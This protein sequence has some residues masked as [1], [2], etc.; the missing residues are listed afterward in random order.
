MKEGYEFT[1]NWGYKAGIRPAKEAV[2][3]IYEGK[4]DAEI[5]LRYTDYYKT[6]PEIAQLALSVAKTE[7]NII[8]RALPNGVS[9]YINIPFCPTRCL[10]C[11]FSSPQSILALH[12][13]PEYLQALYKEITASL[14]I[15][16]ANQ[17]II[18]TI[19]IGGGTPTML[20]TKQLNELLSKVSHL[21]QLKELTVEAGRPDTITREKLEILNRHNVT[22]ISINPQTMND[23]TLMTIGRPHTSEQT[24]AAV[25]LAREYGFNNINM[26]IIAG[27]PNE[28]FEMFAHTVKQV[29]ALNP[30]NITVHAMCIKRTSN[31]KSNAESYAFTDDETV[32]NM[33]KFARETLIERGY[34]PYY[35][36]R[37]KDTLGDCENVG[38]SKPAFD[39]IYNIYM[40][41]EIQSV[42]ACGAG[43]VTKIVDRD[44]SQI[45]RMFNVK[46]A[47]DYINRVDE[48]I[49]RKI[50]LIENMR[51][52]C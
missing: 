39:G 7:K 43:S 23:E 41:A 46:E 21:P 2:R 25:A 28:T 48:M 22:R 47:I 42:I 36:Y 17:N 32:R 44:N 52:L 8:D 18:E 40:M 45:N 10:Y 35:L 49:E 12:L 26:D 38:Y 13:I 5:I 24:Q 19:Y 3:L 51:N 29:I 14:D 1:P 31:L 6:M 9:M 4:T 34:T 50:L 30:E 16:K 27:L 11:S 20:D 15:I 33:V 37:Q